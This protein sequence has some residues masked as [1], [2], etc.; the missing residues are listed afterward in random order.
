MNFTDRSG[1]LW[2]QARRAMPGPLREEWK[3]VGTVVALEGRCGLREGGLAARRVVVDSNGWLEWRDERSARRGP[4][5]VVR[6]ASLDPRARQLTTVLSN[7]GE[8]PCRDLDDERGLVT[9][10]HAAIPDAYNDP[11]KVIGGGMS[12]QQPGGWSGS[13]PV[14][15]HPPTPSYGGGPLPEQP[16]VAIGDITVSSSW[17]VTPAGNRF[18][19]DV[20]WTVTDM[21]RTYRAIPTWAIVMAVIG[22]FFFLLGLFFLLVKEE[23]TEGWVQVTVQAPGFVHVASIPVRRVAEVADIHN[24]VNY[25]RSLTAAAQAR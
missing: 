10:P 20:T 11:R 8:G 22:F 15:G 16:L 9:G 17:V 6:P 12:Y 1:T 23:R 3:C 4:V 19:K 24:R 5:V 25:A 7:Y 13:Q 14:G 21:S 2:W 18:V